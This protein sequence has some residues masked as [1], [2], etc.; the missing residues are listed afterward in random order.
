MDMAALV[1]AQHHY[2]ITAHPDNAAAAPTLGM[3]APPPT[4]PYPPMPPYPIFPPAWPYPVPPSIQHHVVPPHPRSPSD[5]FGAGAVHAL[6][7]V[8]SSYAAAAPS[9]AAS[10]TPLAIPLGAQYF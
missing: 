4:V 3:H 7:A 2:V 8:G 1:S 6:G 5:H 9:A 10:A